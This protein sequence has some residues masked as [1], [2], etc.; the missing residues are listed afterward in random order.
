MPKLARIKPFDEIYGLDIDALAYEMD[1]AGTGFVLDDG[2]PMEGEFLINHL[3][4][5]N[6]ILSEK[7]KALNRQCESLEQQM[8]DDRSKLHQTINNVKRF[9][10][11][12]ILFGNSRGAVMLKMAL[13]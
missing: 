2:T 13:K 9:Y 4:Q 7:V 5:T 11:D 6:D 12:D 10:R 1:C 8:Y 3:I